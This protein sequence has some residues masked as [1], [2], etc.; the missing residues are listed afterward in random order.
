M[1]DNRNKLNGKR[2]KFRIT[3]MGKNAILLVN[4]KVEEARARA[5]QIAEEK[6]G[7]ILVYKQ[8]KGTETLIEF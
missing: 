8:S 6:P 3:G 5:R 2:A 1:Y 7:I 4:F